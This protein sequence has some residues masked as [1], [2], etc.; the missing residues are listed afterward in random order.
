M[1][2]MRPPSRIRRAPSPQ[3]QKGT[4]YIH[5]EHSIEI[6]DVEIANRFALE[7]YARVVDKNVERAQLRNNFVEQVLRF[8]LD[9]D[10]GLN[11]PCNATRISYFGND[12]FRLFRRVQVVYGDSVAIPMQTQRD[13]LAEPARCTGDES[14]LHPS[15]A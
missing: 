14:R 13:G 4:A 7:R 12:R 3:C 5:G 10:I 2:T 6:A 8:T 9:G 15:I 1:E 11:R